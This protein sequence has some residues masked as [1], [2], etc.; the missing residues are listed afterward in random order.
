MFAIRPYPD[1][2]SARIHALDPCHAVDHFLLTPPPLLML[3]KLRVHQSH[4]ETIRAHRR[5]LPLRGFSAAIS[6]RSSSATAFASNVFWIAGAG[7]SQSQNTLA[8]IPATAPVNT[9]SR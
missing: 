4:H 8:S 6:G 1:I 3:A 5:H 9:A 2:I 7:A